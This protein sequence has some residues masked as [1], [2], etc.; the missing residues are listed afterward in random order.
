MQMRSFSFRPMTSIHLSYA[1][2]D[3]ITKCY[4]DSLGLKLAYLWVFND[5][6][7]IFYVFIKIREY[8]NKISYTTFHVM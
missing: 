8:A 6:S 4:N 1:I 5:F 3:S 7:V 2:T